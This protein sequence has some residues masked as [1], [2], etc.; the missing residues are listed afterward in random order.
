[1]L[2]A[3]EVKPKIIHELIQTVTKIGVHTPQ[4]VS[5]MAMVPIQTPDVIGVAP[6]IIESAML[7]K[8]LLIRDDLGSYDR[9]SMQNTSED[10]DFL[11][12]AGTHFIGGKQNRGNDKL[13]I[14][15]SNG[16][17]IRVEAHCFEPDRSQ[18]DQEFNE[19]TESPADV[20]FQTMTSAGT[21]ASWNIIESYHKTF[22]HSKKSLIEFLEHTEKDRFK[23]ALNYETLRDQNGVLSLIG[24]DLIALEIYPNKRTFRKHRDDIYSGKFASM[25]WKKVQESKVA[26]LTPRDV[27]IRIGYFLKLLDEG[28]KEI[29]PVSQ[30]IYRLY[31]IRKAKFIVDLILNGRSEIVYMFA[32]TLN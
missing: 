30:G 21:G 25:F 20:V 13:Q 17:K 23:L 24:D 16:G 19:I 1:M 11:I 32:M 2:K 18:G 3:P 15:E 27:N 12:P 6:E 8:E 29:E 22:R 4:I 14:L 31:T 26:N 7:N 5:G 10:A 9:M 28:L